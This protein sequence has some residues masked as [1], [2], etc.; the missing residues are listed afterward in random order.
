MSRQRTNIFPDSSG[1][2]GAL[3]P[4]P[5]ASGGM[6]RAIP[7]ELK[8]NIGYKIV[9][10]I[11]II[12]TDRPNSNT[13]VSSWSSS[14]FLFFR[15]AYFLFRSAARTVSRVGRILVNHEAGVITQ[16]EETVLG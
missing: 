5:M 3:R 8:K 9:D 14:A 1:M 10:R 13:H 11:D 16:L 7:Y 2:T 6:Y 12:K 4:P 15:I